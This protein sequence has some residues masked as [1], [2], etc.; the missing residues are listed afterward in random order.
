[1]E[2]ID[3]II[4]GIDPGTMVMGYGLILQQGHKL[5]FIDMGVLNLRKELDPLM[6]LKNIHAEIERLIAQYHPNCMAIES[7]F[8]GKNVQSLIKL[9]RAQGVAIA[10]AMK[11]NLEVF[12]YAPLRIKQSIT[13]NGNA[14]KEQV[15]DMLFRLLNLQKEKPKYLDAT[16]ALGAAFCHGL[17]NQT[18]LN[19]SGGK[20]SSSSW[21][22]FLSQNPDRIK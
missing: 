12:E 10:V 3:K 7:S 9:G 2:L 5:S 22:N 13:G 18:N 15:C 14:S 8:Y 1:M 20:T 19:R 11:L 4:L 16:D 6:K 17:Q 21:K